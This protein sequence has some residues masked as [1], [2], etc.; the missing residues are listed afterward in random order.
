MYKRENTRQ[1]TVG[2]IKIGGG[3]KVSIQSM[4]SVPA[5]DFEGNINQAK[6]FAKYMN[7]IG[8][9]YTDKAVDF[10]LVE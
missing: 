3:A 2:N 1:V 5:H 9:F 8:C 10:E 4:L 7:E 6:A